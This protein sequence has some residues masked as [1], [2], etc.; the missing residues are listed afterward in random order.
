MLTRSHSVRLPEGEK[1]AFKLSED[2]VSQNRASDDWNTTFTNT[3][4]RIKIICYY[5]AKNI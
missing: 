1:I 3:L 2:D 4:K 5:V